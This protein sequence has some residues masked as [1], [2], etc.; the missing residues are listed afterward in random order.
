MA[1]KSYHTK[2]LDDAMAKLYV[3][4]NGQSRRSTEESPFVGMGN[5]AMGFASNSMDRDAAAAK[6][7]RDKAAAEKKQEREDIETIKGYRENSE[8]KAPDYEDV[9]YIKYGHHGYPMAKDPYGEMSKEADDHEDATGRTIAGVGTMK[10]FEEN[11]K[12][13]GNMAHDMNLGRS[14][15][16][17]GGMMG[18]NGPGMMVGGGSGIGGTNP[19]LSGYEDPRLVRT[20]PY[21]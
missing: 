1:L 4:T 12:R 13:A 19:M 14:M 9:Q 20:N 10:A 7:A 11:G 5:A 16:S 2:A 8:V 6:K 3:L 15:M 17:E 21:E 18:L